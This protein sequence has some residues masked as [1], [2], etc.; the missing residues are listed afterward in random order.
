M[1][2]EIL[3]EAENLKSFMKKREIKK[4]KEGNLEVQLKVL[5]NLVSKEDMLDKIG[6]PFLCLTLGF[7]FMIVGI[8]T[9]QKLIISILIPLVLI[10]NGLNIPLKKRKYLESYDYLNRLYLK[11]LEIKNQNSHN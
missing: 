3:E 6:N 7:F 10:F 9:K 2:L 11:G 5:S 4:L 1:R 8:L